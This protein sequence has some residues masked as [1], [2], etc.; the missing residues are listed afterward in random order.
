MPMPDER[1]YGISYMGM[2]RNGVPTVGWFQ[3]WCEGGPLTAEQLMDALKRQVGIDDT[4]TD[5]PAPLAV[6]PLSFGGVA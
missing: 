2:G 3:L 1:L 5:T 4:L 6:W